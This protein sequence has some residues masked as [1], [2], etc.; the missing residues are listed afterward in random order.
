MNKEF[1]LDIFEK[2]KND[3]LFP[4]NFLLQDLVLNA[5]KGVGVCG[6]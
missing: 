2:K 5:I 3:I 4:K 6:D 1:K